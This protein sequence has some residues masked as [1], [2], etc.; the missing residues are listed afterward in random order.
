MNRKHD[1]SIRS[2]LM[3]ALRAIPRVPLTKGLVGFAAIALL[4]ACNPPQPLN[5]SVQNV[6][7]SPVGLD[8]DLRLV[9]VTPAAPD[10]R[11]GDL[12]PA[13]ASLTNTW[14][15]ATVE[16]LSRAAIFNDDSHHHVNLE[17]KILK[18]YVPGAGIT[19]PTETDAR[20]TLIDRGNGAVIFSQ[21]ISAIGTTPMDFSLIGA[22][23][24]RESIN[25]SAQNNIAAF[26]SAL[27]HSPGAVARIQRPVS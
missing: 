25:R 27:E 7:V 11:T 22:I 4:A 1:D 18:F 20:Y 24:G 5:F 16:A 9:T 3:Y 2:I 6:A 26:I 15:E 10:E 12:P 17:I 8:Q 23:R 21:T 19:F 14:K 13:V